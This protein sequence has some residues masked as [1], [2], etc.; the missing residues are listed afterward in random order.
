MP[1]NF[2][3]KWPAWVSVLIIPQRSLCSPDKEQATQACEGVLQIA[4]L[5][6]YLQIKVPLLEIHLSNSIRVSQKEEK[7]PISTSIATICCEIFRMT[8]YLFNCSDKFG[9]SKC[10]KNHSCKHRIINYLWLNFSCSARAGRSS[11]IQ[12]DSRL[13]VAMETVAHLH[14]VWLC[15]RFR[16]FSSTLIAKQ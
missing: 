8:G 7:K 15:E 16:D 12:G 14:P 3:S 6:F 1:V 2:H 11:R 5:L 13:S 4:V 10:C 9:D